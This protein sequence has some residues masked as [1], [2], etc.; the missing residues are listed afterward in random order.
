MKKQQKQETHEIDEFENYCHLWNIVP[1]GKGVGIVLLRKII[2]AIHTDNYSSPGNILPSFLITGKE[3]KKLVAKALVNSLKIEDVRTC[4]AQYFDNG[5]PSYEFF[6]DSLTNTAHIITDIEQLNKRAEP[7]LWKY[8]KNRR[9]SYYN[10]TTRAYDNILHCNGLI[11]L[12]A[13]NTNSIPDT[14]KKA[15]DYI[16]ELEPFTI[17]QLEAVIHQRLFFCGVEYDGEE[18]LKEIVN[19]GKGSME[20]IIPFLKK[21]LMLVKS[22]IGEC[23][24]MGIVNRSKRISQVGQLPPPIGDDIPF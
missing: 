18:V 1:S 19:I 11:I 5:I 20:L 14:I 10:N 4:P 12:T 15:I 3:G 16:I 22:E 9:C 21:C 24:T 13:G 6:W 23:L 7:T 2:D 8:L 17:D